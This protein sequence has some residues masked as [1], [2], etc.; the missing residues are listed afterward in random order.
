MNLEHETK[1]QSDH[2]K[3]L[4]AEVERLRALELPMIDIKCNGCSK[5]LRVPARYSAGIVYCT[6]ECRVMD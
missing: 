2:I 1:L 6:Y 5:I 4:E 3:E